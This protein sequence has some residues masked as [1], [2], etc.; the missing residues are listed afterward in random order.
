MFMTI[1]CRLFRPEKMVFILK[2]EVQKKSLS[3]PVVCF[4]NDRVPNV[5]VV[6]ILKKITSYQPPQQGPYQWFS[7]KILACHA[8]APGSIPG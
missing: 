5:H 3:V 1:H 7:G 6:F 2:F 4:S 8:S